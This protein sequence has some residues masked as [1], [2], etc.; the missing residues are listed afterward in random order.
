MTNVLLKKSNC[1]EEQSSITCPCYFEQPWIATGWHSQKQVTPDQS[2]TWVS[3]AIVSI[4]LHWVV[5]IGH[6][7]LEHCSI[8]AFTHF[9]RAEWKYCGHLIKREQESKWKHYKSSLSLQ[10][11]MVG[12]WCGTHTMGKRRL[13]P[14]PPS[15]VMEPP[16]LCHQPPRL[17]NPLMMKVLHIETSQRVA[18]EL[19]EE[20][21]EQEGNRIGR[22]SSFRGLNMHT[23]PGTRSDRWKR[24]RNKTKTKEKLEKRPKQGTQH[25]FHIWK[26]L[27]LAQY[28]TQTGVDDVLKPEV[29]SQRS[30]KELKA[31]GLLKLP[32]FY[33]CAS[34]LS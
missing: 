25:A 6:Y 16:G 20:Q 32:L 11:A 9:H 10:P 26:R 15:P 21:E 12:H 1:S 5:S 33:F 19:Q 23:S 3:S 30:P 31:F 22:S 13:R 4:L 18:T 34:W 29:K 28:T 17:Q 7:I 2:R 14:P 24:Q 27:R 8:A